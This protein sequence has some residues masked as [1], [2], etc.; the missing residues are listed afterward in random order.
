M[1]GGFQVGIYAMGKKYLSLLET[2]LLFAIVDKL[3]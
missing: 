2:E 3:L 1:V